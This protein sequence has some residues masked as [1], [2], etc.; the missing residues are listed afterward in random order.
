MTIQTSVFQPSITNQKQKL[1]T[2]K[3]TWR[4]A[5]KINREAVIA[6]SDVVI[7]RK[8]RPVQLADCVI[9]SQTTIADTNQTAYES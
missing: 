8:S 5:W 3:T 1:V 9:D 6:P 2:I 7:V 4:V